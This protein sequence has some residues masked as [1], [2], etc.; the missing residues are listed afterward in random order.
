MSNNMKTEVSTTGAPSAIG[1]YSQAIRSGNLLFVSGQIPMD[2]QSGELVDGDISQQTELVL[3]NLKN[4]I[5]AA[6]SHMDQIVKCTI[7]IKNMNQFGE[8]NAVYDRFFTKPYP[9][10]ACVEVSN[11]PK[12]VDVEIDAIANIS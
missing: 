7:F 6:G 9:A 5:E 1:P 12:D 2:P 11:L 10:R 4:I 3:N 8:I